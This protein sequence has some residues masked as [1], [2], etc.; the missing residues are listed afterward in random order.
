MLAAA[1]YE[2]Q[3][4]ARLVGKPGAPASVGEAWFGPDQ[5]ETAMMPADVLRQS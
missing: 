5:A 4:F 1:T 3:K 2:G